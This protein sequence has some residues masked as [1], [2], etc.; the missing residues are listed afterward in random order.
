MLGGL[1]RRSATAAPGFFLR[2]HGNQRQQDDER[3]TQSDQQGQHRAAHL[4]KLMGI[5]PATATISEGLHSV[6]T[7]TCCCG[8]CDRRQKPRKFRR[9]F[10]IKK[11]LLFLNCPHVPL[12]VRVKRRS[13]VVS[14]RSGTRGVMCLSERRESE[15][16]HREAAAAALS[17]VLR[18][19]PTTRTKPRSESFL[20]LCSFC[21]SALGAQQ[22]QRSRSGSRHEGLHS[23]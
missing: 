12:E 15:E 13:S 14:Q 18:F 1:R 3:V 10:S 6:S 17:G 21:I 9:S 4:S 11:L 16:T 8:F 22:L 7:E 23:V 2:F 5:K 19:T 20:L